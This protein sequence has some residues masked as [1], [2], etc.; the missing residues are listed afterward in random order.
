MGV[1]YNPYAD[2]AV[3]GALALIGVCYMLWRRYHHS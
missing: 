2:A 1:L 3:V